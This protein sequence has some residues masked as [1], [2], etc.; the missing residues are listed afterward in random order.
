MMVSACEVLF[1][2]RPGEGLT[3]R[4]CMEDGGSPS[5]PFGQLFFLFLKDNEAHA[6]LLNVSSLM[7]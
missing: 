2:S 1:I 3:R 6:E 7:A 5:L 4:V